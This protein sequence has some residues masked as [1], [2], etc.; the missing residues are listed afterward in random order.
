L[1]ASKLTWLP[2]KN[3]QNAELGRKLL[4]GIFVNRNKT[5]GVMIESSGVSFNTGHHITIN[6]HSYFLKHSGENIEHSIK[7]TYKQ[8]KNSPDFFKSLLCK[9]NNA[10]ISTMKKIRIPSI[11]VIQSNI[12]LCLTSILYPS[13][14]QFVEA[15]MV[16]IST[17]KEIK[18]EWMKVFELLAFLEQ[19]LKE[20]E[21]IMKQVELEA[22]GFTSLSENDIRV[23]NYF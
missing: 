8:M 3:Y 10:S 20:S 23:K 2:P 13:K 4:D 14:W 22:A 17:S 11:M 19:V 16:Y 12:T 5:L 9:Y 21:R 6:I 1:I 15:R 7:D 18:T